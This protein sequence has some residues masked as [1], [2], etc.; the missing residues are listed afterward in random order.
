[1][2]ISVVVAVGDVG[3]QLVE[4]IRVRMEKLVIGPASD[5]S[6]EMGPLITR[7]ARDRVAGYIQAGAEA[8]CQV[9]V[10]GRDQAFEGDGFFLWGSRCSITSPPT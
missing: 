1:M 6:S 3:D 2:A 9:V 4:A 8:G 5:P 10:D 7:E